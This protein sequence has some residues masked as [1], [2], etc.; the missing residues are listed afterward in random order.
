MEKKKQISMF[1]DLEILK[2][3][4]TVAMTT[5]GC[6]K[7]LTILDHL[8]FEYVIVEEAAEVL[9]PHILSLFIKDIKRLIMIGDHKQLKPKP[10]SYEL[11]KKYNFNVSMFERLINN[12]IKYVRLIYQRRIKPLF[13]DFVRLIYGGKEYIDKENEDEAYKENIRGMTSDMFIVTHKK[14]ESNIEGMKIKC[15][16]YEAYYLVKLCS[17]LLKQGYK[18]SQIIFLTFYVGQAMKILEII[19]DSLLEEEVKENLKV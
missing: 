14:P 3:K 5:T 15:N 7:Y 16:E 18:S 8:K 12:G 17:Y 9:E 1:V 10:Y 19:K 6:A 11:C 2:E 4:K 13:T